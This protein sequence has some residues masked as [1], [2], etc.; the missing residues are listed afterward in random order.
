[1]IVYNTHYSITSR[2]PVLRTMKISLH[3]TYM[4]SAR[5]QNWCQGYNFPIFLDYWHHLRVAFWGTKMVNFGSIFLFFGSFYA[6]L[7]LWNESRLGN[8]RILNRFL[9]I[10]SQ[11]WSSGVS[12]MATYIYIWVLA[13]TRA[14]LT[15]K[16]ASPTTCMQKCRRP[17]NIHP[18]IYIHR[19]DILVSL[20]LATF[21]K[22]ELW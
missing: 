10:A 7:T 17:Y 2:K 20:I 5:Q 19:G 16:L 6:G 21:F 14:L 22:I 18:P 3:Q 13:S 4:G 8:F 9:D 12:K 1:M 15:K 11:S